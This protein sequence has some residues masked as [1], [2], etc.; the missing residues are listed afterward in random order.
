MSRPEKK[1][2][3]S[4]YEEACDRMVREKK[5]LAQIATEMQMDMTT[6]EA[7]ALEHNPMFQ[8]A[9]WAA[10]HKFY[11]ELAN[12][13]ERSKQSAVGQMIFAIQGLMEKGDWDKAVEAILKLAKLEGWIGADS[14][15]NVFTELRG[16]QFEELKKRAMEKL[17]NLQ[18]GSA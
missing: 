13:P 9:L 10:R 3:T 2:T 15:V 4:W 12:N 18:V 7:F 14:N 5:K 8:K 6:E 1:K 17:K 16:E 11:Q